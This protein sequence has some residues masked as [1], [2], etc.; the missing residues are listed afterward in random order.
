MIE[1]HQVAKTFQS[2]EGPVPALADVSLSVAAGE[3]LTLIGPSGS[4][5]TTL[6]RIIGSLLEPTSGVVR[7]NGLSP[8]EARLQ[9]MFSFVFQKPVLLPWRRVVENVSLPL[10]IVPRQTRDPQALLG[11]V[12]LEGF[13]RKYP[14]ELSGGMQQR[15]AIARALTFDPQVLFMDEPFGA[16]D[17]L[18]RDGLNLQLLDLWA[19]IRVT[20]IFIT[21]SISE[22]VFLADRVVLL[23]KRPSH[24]D[25]IVTV[26]FQRPRSAELKG[27]PEFQEVVRWLRQRLESSRS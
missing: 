16:L 2:D 3:F 18:T 19:R 24:I 15:V 13:D 6:I 1:L 27:T 23:S 22:A 25:E 14:H 8:E 26:S 9:G 11:L 5:K 4:G 17:E 10:E 12:G 20:I 7:V 21:H